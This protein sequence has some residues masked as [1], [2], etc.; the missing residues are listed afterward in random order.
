VALQNCGI[1]VRVNEIL[2]RIIAKQPAFSGGDVFLQIILQN[3]REQGS[4]I[5][6]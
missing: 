6:H 1:R 5:L 4:L 2:D 3:L